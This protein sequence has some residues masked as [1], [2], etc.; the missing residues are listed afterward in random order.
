MPEFAGF[1]NF[2][3][4]FILIYLVGWIVDVWIESWRQ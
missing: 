3:A 2:I 1:W 4:W